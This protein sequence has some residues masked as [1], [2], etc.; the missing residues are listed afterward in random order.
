MRWEWKIIIIEINSRKSLVELRKRFDFG[1]V[2]IELCWVCALFSSRDNDDSSIITQKCSEF[3]SFIFFFSSAMR[4]FF[5]FFHFHSILSQT[6]KK[7]I[8][9]LFN[10]HCE[11]MCFLMS[12]TLSCVNYQMR[13]DTRRGGCKA[14]KKK[15]FEFVDLDFSDG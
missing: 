4:N 14:R 8:Q 3:Y 15:K 2:E 12:L 7:I 11:W 1:L 6:H 9:W 10:I 5:H 13:W